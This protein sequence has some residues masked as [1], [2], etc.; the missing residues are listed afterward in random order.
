I[1]EDMEERADPEVYV[2]F[3]QAAERTVYLVIRADSNPTALVASVRHEVGVLDQQVPVFNVKLMEQLI[4]ERLSPKRMA[5]YG[6]GCGA[7]I[8]LLLATVGIYSVIS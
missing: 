7:L 4:D 2:P 3:A 1:N 5:V 8:A 6:L